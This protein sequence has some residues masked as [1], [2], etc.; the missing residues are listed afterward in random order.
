MTSSA[1]REKLETAWGVPLSGKVGTTAVH[2][3]SK[4]ETG[5]I[6]TLYIM[7]EDPMMSDPDVGHVHHCLESLNFPVA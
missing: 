7:G 1:G 5:E 6:K 4:V 3:L 2:M